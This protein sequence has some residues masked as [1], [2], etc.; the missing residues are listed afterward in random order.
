MPVQFDAANNLPA[1]AEVNAHVVQV[2]FAL[3]LVM[4]KFA[5]LLTMTAFVR[6]Y[7]AS[8]VSTMAAAGVLL[9]ELDELAGLA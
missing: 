7:G 9:P 8:V 6:L 1:S 5:P 2:T 3:P 4:V